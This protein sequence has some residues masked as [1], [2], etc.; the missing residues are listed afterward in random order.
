MILMSKSDT[1]ERRRIE[2]V[3]V[4]KRLNIAT[5]KERKKIQSEKE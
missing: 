2:Q 5:V 3:R 1:E 4:K